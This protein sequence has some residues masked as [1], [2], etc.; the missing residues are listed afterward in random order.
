MAPTFLIDNSFST[1]VTL[2]FFGFNGEGSDALINRVYS[3]LLKTNR[4]KLKQR[5]RNI[6]SI[7]SPT[8]KLE[9]AATYIRP[10]KDRLI[11]EKAIT[12]ISRIY[13]NLKVT[14]IPGGHFI[15]Q[16]NPEK[17]AKMIE[18]AMEELL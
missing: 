1:K 15:A 8:H 4:R 14:N 18:N 9:I 6:A 5:L 10:N 2:N 3:S 17:V 13:V 7:S 12:E 11:K 16:A